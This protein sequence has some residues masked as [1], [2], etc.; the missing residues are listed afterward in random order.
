MSPRSCLIYFRTLRCRSNG[1]I[2]HTAW[3]IVRL[4]VSL[5]NRAEWR[6]TNLFLSA[7]KKPNYYY[8]APVLTEQ[9]VNVAGGACL[10]V[11]LLDIV[12]GVCSFLMSDKGHPHEE[13]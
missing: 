6:A 13:T 8:Y 10:K 4:Y 12:L 2:N 1:S 3:T 9:E 7:N 5:G 11:F